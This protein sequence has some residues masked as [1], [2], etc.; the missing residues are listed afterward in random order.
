MSAWKSD[1]D[2][3]SRSCGGGI[4]GSRAEEIRGAEAVAGPRRSGWY[5]R[6]GG[7]GPVHLHPHPA[8]LHGMS[9]LH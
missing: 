9:P 5:R 4:P 3:E 2:L 1:E 7:P 6:S 8:F